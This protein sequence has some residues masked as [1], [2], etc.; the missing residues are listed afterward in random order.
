MGGRLKA[1]FDHL[2]EIFS[3]EFWFWNGLPNDSRAITGVLA[4]LGEDG[5]GKVPVAEFG[6]GGTRIAS[7]RLFF[8][9]GSVNDKTSSGTTEITAKTWHHV[10]L[11]SNGRRVTVYLD[12]RPR[13][14]IDVPVEFAAVRGPGWLSIGGRADDGSAFEGKIDEIALY[15]RA[16]LAD[17]ISQ[18]LRAAS[19]PGAR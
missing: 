18:H 17:E 8:T 6:I 14:E 9:A 19:Q 1:E 15:D 10:A 7:S 3:V 5:A 4:S 12:G 13:P 16:L 2:P 11:V